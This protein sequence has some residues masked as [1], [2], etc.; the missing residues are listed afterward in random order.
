MLGLRY[1]VLA[2]LPAKK[3]EKGE[4][5][6]MKTEDIDKG[7]MFKTA[8]F[9][10]LDISKEIDFLG[11]KVRLFLLSNEE[12]ESVFRISTD[13]AADILLRNIVIKKM[14]LAKSISS[15]DGIPFGGVTNEQLVELSKEEKDAVYLKRTKILDKEIAEVLD[16]LTQEYTA[17]RDFYLLVLYER[18]KEMEEGGSDIQ[19][20]FSVNGVLSNNSE[21]VKIG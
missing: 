21:D 11:K 7:L 8:L 16:Q 15:I 10:D 3:I 19:P 2:Q 17:F 1:I 18:V 12:T 9:G 6:K 4:K 13:Y 5:C 14:V 20:P